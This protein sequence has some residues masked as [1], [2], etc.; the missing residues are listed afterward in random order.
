M[1]TVSLTCR[2]LD[3][4]FQMRDGGDEIVNGPIQVFLEI[5]QFVFCY[6][7]L[8]IKFFFF[9]QGNNLPAAFEFCR[10]KLTPA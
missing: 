1:Q 8:A 3:V 9:S 6:R 5:W 2:Q 10:H 4:L 7:T